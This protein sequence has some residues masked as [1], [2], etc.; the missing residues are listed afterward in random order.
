MQQSASGIWTSL[1]WLYWFGIF[2]TAPIA[3]KT[4]LNLKVVKSDLKMIILLRW[5]KYVTH[6][7]DAGEQKKLN[8]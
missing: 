8:K 6:S 2:A 4:I 7:V 3:S 1:T 5:S